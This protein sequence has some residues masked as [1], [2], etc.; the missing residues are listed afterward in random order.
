MELQDILNNKNLLL[1]KEDAILTKTI[2]SG[3]LE[4]TFHF[5]T[6]NSLQYQ[7]II[8]SAISELDLSEILKMT[9]SS[10]KDEVTDKNEITD[11]N[12][13]NVMKSLGFKDLVAIYDKI[14]VKCLISSKETK[15][16][17]NKKSFKKLQENFPPSIRFEM[18][19]IIIEESGLGERKPDINS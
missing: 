15:K 14:L 8:E 18:G 19:Q 1:E 13:S 17:I 4:L 11:E 7:S 9:N 16:K 2:Y 12:V 3:D 5:N 10:E 6:I